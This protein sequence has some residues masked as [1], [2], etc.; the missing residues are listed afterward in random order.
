MPLKLLGIMNIRNEDK[1]FPKK[2]KKTLN[3]TV[4]VMLLATKTAVAPLIVATN[5]GVMGLRYLRKMD[6]ESYAKIYTTNEILEH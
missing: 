4:I 6:M 1:M 3:L 2:E 5:F